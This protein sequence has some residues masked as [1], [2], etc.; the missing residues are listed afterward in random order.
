[1][2]YF[3]D[4]VEVAMRDFIFFGDFRMAL[5]EEE[6]RIYEDIQDYEVVKV[7]FQVWTGF[8]LGVFSFREYF[9]GESSIARVEYCAFRRWSW[10]ECLSFCFQV[11]NEGLCFMQGFVYLLVYRNDLGDLLNVQIFGFIFLRRFFFYSC[12]VLGVLI[13][14][15]VWELF[16]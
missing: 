1:M 7:L 6:T 9:S 2:E 5:Y 3:E 16:I 8:F 11:W 12:R 4:D 10:E 14:S 13:Y 15:Q